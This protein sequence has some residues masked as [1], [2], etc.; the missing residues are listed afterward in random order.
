MLFGIFAKLAPKGVKVNAC[1]KHIPFWKEKSRNIAKTLLNVKLTLL[2]LII[3]K[4]NV[5]SIIFS[6]PIDKSALASTMDIFEQ[7]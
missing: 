6:F 3:L 7:Y 5:Y 2:S 1:L 4:L